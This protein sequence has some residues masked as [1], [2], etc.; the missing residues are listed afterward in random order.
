M[1]VFCY[2]WLL[3]FV[4]D[5]IGRLCS[6][7]RSLG[8][9]LRL[10]LW[11]VDSCCRHDPATCAACLVLLPLR[12]RWLDP[13]IR[14]VVTVEI[15]ARKVR[16]TGPRGSLI[17]IVR[18]LNMEMVKVDDGRRVRID[19]WHGHRKQLAQIN[20][21]KSMLENLITGV[22]RGFRYKLRFVY[23]HFPINGSVTDDGKAVELRNFL[24]EK[25]VRRVEMLSGVTCYRSEK[26]KDELVVE[27]SDLDNV[28][29]SAASV[30]QS[31]LVRR[32][33]IRKFLDGVY[34]SE[35]GHI[36]AVE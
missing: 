10:L 33:D 27:G 7:I 31:C 30:H 3:F 12:A 13:D 35:K 22:T 28:S 1:Y 11:L 29:Q 9:L 26:V 34:V 14:A 4:S 16:V 20:T 15:K 6:T 19:V 5:A 21:A 18:H 17:R 2:L 23:A 25:R 8:T 32:K 24:G 36:E